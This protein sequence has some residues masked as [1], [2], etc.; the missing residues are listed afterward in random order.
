V[1]PYLSL[2]KSN[3]KSQIVN[4]K[5]LPAPSERP[6]DKKICKKSKISLTNNL[7]CTTRCT[8]ALTGG[9]R[10][11]HPPKTSS[12]RKGYMH[13]CFQNRISPGDAENPYQSN[14]ISNSP[15]RQAINLSVRDFKDTAARGPPPFVILSEAQRSRRIQFYSANQPY[16]VAKELTIF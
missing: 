7:L 4:L 15:K 2:P 5:T 3:R 10:D 9:C 16:F 8:S 1:T 14:A 11:T 13:P 12:W 6:F